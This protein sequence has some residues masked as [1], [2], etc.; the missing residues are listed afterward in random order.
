MLKYKNY[1]V[2]ERLEEAYKLNQNKNNSIVAGN[3]FLKMKNSMRNT[4]IDLSNLGLSYI[5]EDES[6]FR[7]G[8]MTSLRDLQLNQA[9]NEFTNYAMD[10][11]LKCIVGVQFRNCATVGGSIWGRFGF[12]DVLTIFLVLDSYVRLYKGGVVSLKDFVDMKYDRDIL[13]EII[14]KKNKAKVAYEYFRNQATD[15]PVLTCAMS[16]CDNNLNIAVGARPMKAMLVST[17]YDDQNI[18][19]S[20]DK[21]VFSSNMRASKNYR[22]EL[23]KVLISRCL[24]K[25]KGENYE[26]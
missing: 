10:D 14:V 15:F 5:V 12:S 2:C 20:L 17:K 3:A 24:K 19:K 26:N 6:E 23:C 4:L 25:I 11:A 1:V 16:L 21:F 7:I 8:A 22:Y 13:I 9:I 18:S